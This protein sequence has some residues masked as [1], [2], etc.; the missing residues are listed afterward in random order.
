[1]DKN[2][3]IYTQTIVLSE[4]ITCMFATQ[5]VI[6]SAGDDLIKIKKKP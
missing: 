3:Q 5:G 2:Y 4:D 6:S 1:M